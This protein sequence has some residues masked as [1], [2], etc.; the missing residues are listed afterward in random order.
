MRVINCALLAEEVDDFNGIAS[1]PE[2]MAEIAVGADFLTDS[3]AELQK[4]AGI[5][6]HE[7]GMHFKGEFADAVFASKFRGFL[8]VGDDFFFPLPVLHFGVF[9]RP[10][11]G[12]PVGLGVCFG[13]AGTA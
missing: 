5:V 13:S 4:R 11:V 2:K 1:L 3:F 7:I 12:Y 6:D 9:G 10:A 8:P